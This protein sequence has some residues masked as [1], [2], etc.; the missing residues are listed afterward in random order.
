VTD[1]A[2]ARSEPDVFPG[3]E[4]DP[5]PTPS[6]LPVAPPAYAAQIPSRYRQ[7]ASAS[8]LAAGLLGL[9]D[10][11]EP[12]K[13]D[14]PVI[15]QHREGDDVDRAVEVYLDPDDPAASLVVIRDPHDAN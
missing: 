6:M 12:P 15:E 4:P 9:R 3:E 14:R 2:T 5:G 11:I 8:I 10:I 7:S 1:D 13:D